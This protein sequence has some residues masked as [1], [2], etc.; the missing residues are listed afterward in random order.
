MILTG[1]GSTTW[2]HLKQQPMSAWTSKAAKD[3]TWYSAWTA[4]QTRIE[5]SRRTTFP[6]SRRR[7]D[8]RPRV[9][10]SSINNDHASQAL[11]LDHALLDHKDSHELRFLGI[12]RIS[13]QYMMA[14]G[15]L[16]PA[17]AGSVLPYA[18]ALSSR[19]FVWA[20]SLVQHGAA[21]DCGK[22]CCTT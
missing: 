1:T 10:Y 12:T 18:T 17:F 9:L 4:S 16:E 5:V 15:R 8:S 19:V 11:L 7:T 13:G 2:T 21:D 3:D 14:T 20:N 6:V 22:D